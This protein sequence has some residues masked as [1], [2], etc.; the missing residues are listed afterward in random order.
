MAAQLRGDGRA[1]NQLREL[2]CARGCLA[3]ADGSARFSAGGAEAL[4]GAWGP[5]A[6]AAR[7]EAAE[8]C[9]VDVVWRPCSGGAATGRERALEAVLRGAV[10]AAAILG[11]AP[12]SG[13]TVVVQEVSA[14]GAGDALAVGI[15]AAFAALADAGFPLRNTLA[16][17]AV[18]VAPGGGLL[19]DPTA[20]EEAGAEAVVTVAV[21]A[22]AGATPG[23]HDAPE[24]EDAGAVVCEARGRLDEASLVEAVAAA[25]S[26]ALRVAAFARVSLA[27]AAVAK[28]A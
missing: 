4:A 6:V 1:A 25:R 24:G 19:L 14:D 12:R 10:E 17:A 9:A 18:A 5:R 13:L 7:H 15:N 8:R 22:P 16:A 11:A 23:A 2:R 26:A 21:R 3:R 28:G 27:R 20:E